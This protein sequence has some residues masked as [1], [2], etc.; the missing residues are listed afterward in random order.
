MENRD[1]KQE[2]YYE[3]D[4]N[5]HKL[6][7]DIKSNL[8]IVFQINSRIIKIL[9]DEVENMNQESLNQMVNTRNLLL[10]KSVSIINE[11]SEIREKLDSEAKVKIENIL[12]EINEQ[13]SI[14]KNLFEKQLDI[15]KS[16]VIK[17]SQKKN[18]KAYE[19][20]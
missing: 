2:F 15:L 9:E 16:D 17:Y 19:R 14:I 4:N 7:D 18:I 12:L 6:M 13:E 3:L 8:N 10:Q 11:E 1:F 20:N 5:L